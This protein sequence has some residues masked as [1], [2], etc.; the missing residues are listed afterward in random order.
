[1]EKMPIVFRADM[2]SYVH[3]NNKGKDI[4]TLG[5]RPTHGL[6]DITLTA[7]AKYPIHF[8]LSGKYLF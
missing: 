2:S 3:V 1:M 4:L 5:E 8:T 7:E 6:D